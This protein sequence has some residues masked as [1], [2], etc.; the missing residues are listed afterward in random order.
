MSNVIGGPDVNATG[1]VDPRSGSNAVSHPK[2]EVRLE[3]LDDAPTP[4][5]KFGSQTPPSGELV[6]PENGTNQLRIG[7]QPPP[8]PRSP[9]P[10]E[11]NTERK[12]EGAPLRDLPTGVSTDGP[13][14]EEDEPRVAKQPPPRPN[15]PIPDEPDE[16]HVT[17][18][19]DVAFEEVVASGQGVGMRPLR[20]DPNEV[21][22]DVAPR[23][24][25][26]PKDLELPPDLELQQLEEVG[27][28]IDFMIAQQTEQEQQKKIDTAVGKLFDQR[29]ESRAPKW[30]LG[31]A[32]KGF[33]QKIADKISDYKERK[34][35]AKL[36]ADQRIDRIHEKQAGG[37][38]QIET[39]AQRDIILDLFTDEA[40]KNVVPQMNSDRN[41][42]IVGI[43][44]SLTKI[45]DDI[46]GRAKAQLRN[47]ASKE[48]DGDP[49]MKSWS[50]SKKEP[51]IEKKVNERL[52]EAT[53]R[54]IRDFVRELVANASQFQRSNISVDALRETLEPAFMF[55]G[56][57]EKQIFVNALVDE[58][59]AHPIELDPQQV[60]IDRLDHDDRMIAGKTGKVGTYTKPEAIVIAGMTDFHELSNE[61]TNILKR[62][63]Q[64]FHDETTNPAN[65]PWLEFLGAA[66]R[67]VV[68]NSFPGEL[69]KVTPENLLAFAERFEE[70]GRADKAQFCRTLAHFI[71]TA[72]GSVE[73]IKSLMLPEVMAHLREVTDENTFFRATTYNPAGNLFQMLGKPEHG[74]QL[75]PILKDMLQGEEVKQLDKDMNEFQ[76]EQDK[77]ELQK[78]IKKKSG[79][80]VDNEPL[81]PLGVETTKVSKQHAERVVKVAED[82]L[83]KLLDVP[84]PQPMVDQLREFADV[85]SHRGTNPNDISQ[86]KANSL[87]HKLFSNELVLRHFTPVLATYKEEG[88][89]KPV[90]PTEV[91]GG[92]KDKGEVAQNLSS[93]SVR[94]AIEIILKV[95]NGASN[96]S[97]YK[98]ETIGQVIANGAGARMLGKIENFFVQAGMPEGAKVQWRQRPQVEQPPVDPQPNQNPQVEQPN[99]DPQVPQP[100]LDVQVQQPQI[101]EQK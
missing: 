37:P 18:D 47:D 71:E 95:A 25:F 79:F 44:N 24:T 54:D 67:H 70:D 77:L 2:A 93:Q 78:P 42:S 45:I 3:N 21:L 32:I 43:S 97:S 13:T 65:L 75:T 10:D 81:Q 64:D 28:Q 38:S 19:D 15:S 84:L 12:D 63:K 100:N 16:L 96:P 80:S 99:K 89:E 6:H 60:E 86:Q 5:P 66:A 1:F 58:L 53:K 29:E 68:I 49:A 76:A 23:Q 35:E 94:F 90:D 9:I 59:V 8:R 31:G 55:I 52:A 74:K 20:D 87:L 17:G 36:T 30:S 101:N 22:D 91:K 34:A 14:I 41:L 11:V 50:A 46:R 33:I 72:N 7:N 40:N 92:E 39:F 57:T 73:G 26:D 4:P 83:D 61:L 56:H 69:R 51:L 98:T 82:L 62:V 85:L 88:V 27:K 48:I